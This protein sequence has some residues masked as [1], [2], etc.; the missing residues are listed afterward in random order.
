MNNQRPSMGEQLLRSLLL[1]LA[2]MWLLNYF[3]G[4]PGGP[5]KADEARPAAAISKATLANAF[6]GL[7]P[8]TGQRITPEAAQKEIA[9]LKGEVGANGTDKYAYWARLRTGLLQQYVLK[10]PVEAMK[11]YDEVIAHNIGDDVDAQAIFQKGDWQWRAASATAASTSAPAPSNATSN[12]TSNVATTAAPV[13]LQP[14]RQDAVVTFEQLIHRGRAASAFLDYE[15]YVPKLPEGTTPSTLA[16]AIPLNELPPLGFTKAKVRELRGTLENPNPL[17][18]LDRINA[19]YSTTWLN[20][21]F[22]KIVN[23]FGANPVFSYGLAIIFLATIMRIVMQPINKKQYESMKGM[24]EIGPEMKKVQ[25]KYKAKPTDSAEVQRDKQMK[26]FSEVRALQK[27]HNVNPQLGCVLMF[28]QL[29]VFFYFI[30]PLM[31]HYEPKMDLVGASFLWIQTLAHPDYY[32]LAVYGVSMLV[33]FRLSSTPPTD[34]MQ[35]QMQLM[36]TFV[37]PV[38]LPFFMKGFSSA[39]ILYWIVFN[40]VSMLFQVRMMKAADPNKD[41]LKTLIGEG[42]PKFGKTAEA[43]VEAVPP[44]PKPQPAKIGDKTV[45]RSS[46]KTLSPLDESATDETANGNGTNG[47]NHKNGSAKSTLNG[48]A[49]QSDDATDYEAVPSGSGASDGSDA[50]SASGAR[51]TQSSQRAR[52]RRRH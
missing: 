19:F 40:C 37:M 9:T 29:P 48:A 20:T 16:A 13:A 11:S 24:Q 30:N 33:S 10:Q 39:F 28:V 8:L 23:L 3:F 21:F 1:S 7:D 38:M 32:L 42:L 52:R 43:A 27:A 49:N 41:I 50:A 5:Q 51:R 47:A 45:R 25:E 22:D 46:I 14:T 15:V 31:M 44:R 18:I 2:A 26:M 17:G 34:D 12:A 6:N 35:R 36:T 4:W